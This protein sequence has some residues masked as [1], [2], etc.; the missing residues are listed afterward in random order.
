MGHHAT[1]QDGLGEGYSAKSLLDSTG[2]V[3]EYSV[4]VIADQSNRSD[5]DDE[6]HRDH[7]GVFGNVLTVF[8]RPNS[9]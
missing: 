1:K 3:G 5:D 6:N 2:D 4:R 8:V 9:A 7:D